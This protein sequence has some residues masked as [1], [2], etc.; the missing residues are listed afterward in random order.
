MRHTYL[1]EEVLVV[2]DDA[3]GEVVLHAVDEL[4]HLK[5]KG[6]RLRC[7]VLQAWMHSG[8]GLYT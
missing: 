1:V 5:T 7:I 3:G 6:C 2:G 8:A 4:E